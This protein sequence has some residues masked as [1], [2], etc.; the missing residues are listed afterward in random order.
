MKNLDE[1]TRHRTL[2]LKNNVQLVE[3]L[4]EF[5][6]F[7]ALSQMF[8]MDAINQKVDN[9]IIHKEEHLKRAA[10][11]AAQGRVGIINVESW[12]GVA[13]DLRERLDLFYNRY[14][15]RNQNTKS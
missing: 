3:D 2:N 5:S 6:P 10:D 12:I 14:E 15:I 13:E 11:D 1:N 7:G 8:I 4:M 9:I